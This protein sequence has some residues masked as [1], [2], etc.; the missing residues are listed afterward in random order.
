[1]SAVWIF[2]AS[3]GT[4]FARSLHRPQVVANEVTSRSRVGFLAPIKVPEALG[5]KLHSNQPT[6]GE[7]VGLDGLRHRGSRV[8]LQTTAAPS[9]LGPH[10]V[11][12]LLRITAS[13]KALLLGYKH[14]AKILTDEAAERARIIRFMDRDEATNAWAVGVWNR[15]LL[16]DGPTL[17]EA[18]AEVQL[19]PDIVRTGRNGRTSGS[20]FT[21]LKLSES[22]N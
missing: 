13:V 6:D 20:T 5:R 19:L 18:R 17:E 4:S 16:G 3:G 8:E 12:A 14:S 22:Q 9:E 7:P 10:V 21:L 2:G 1:M 15:I 11:G